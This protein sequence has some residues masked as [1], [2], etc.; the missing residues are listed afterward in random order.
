MHQALE[1]RIAGG[2]LTDDAV[3][4]RLRH[5]GS[6]EYAEIRAVLQRDEMLLPPRSDAATYVEFAAV[7]LELLY[8][9]P[10]QLPW[11]FPALLQRDRVAELLALDLDHRA[12][13]EATRLAGAD[14]RTAGEFDGPWSLDFAEP[15]EPDADPLRPSPPAYWRLI[16]RAEKAGLLGNASQ[17]GHLAAESVAVGAARP[18]PGSDRAGPSR[19]GAARPPAAAGARPA[20]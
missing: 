12:L 3:L 1:R 16:A 10:E 13:Y 20:R 18:G 9:A 6:T 8:F 5:I 11:H 2:Q 7:F 17:G 14:N 15:Q 4:E 19:V